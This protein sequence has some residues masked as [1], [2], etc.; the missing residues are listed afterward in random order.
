MKAILITGG[1][2]F[3]GSNLTRKILEKGD[4]QVVCLD[5][6]DPFYPK[7]TK[8]KNIEPFLKNQNYQ[9][10]EGDILKQ[11]DLDI[12]PNVD[13]I[14]H[15]AA[16]TGVRP[17][18]GDAVKYHEVNSIG[19]QM[20]LEFARHR[21]IQKF[22]FASSSSVYGMN[23]QLPW[24]E[25]SSLFPIS[26]YASSK[27][28]AEIMGYVY[29][30][31]YNIRFLS[32]RLFTVYGPGQR[33][34]LAIRNFFDAILSEVPVSVFGDGSSKRDYTYIDDV[35][36][37]IES[38]LHFSSSMYEIFNI[39]GQNPISLNQLIEEI[40]LICNRKAVVNRFPSQTGDVP[41]TFADIT[42]AKAMINYNP[43]HTIQQGLAK[44]FDWVKSAKKPELI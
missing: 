16:K 23:D 22:I 13:A 5:N 43:S 36:D 34:D 17:S 20:L 31:L 3:I 44:H 26:P 10:I 30:S 15:L 35:L 21:S 1:A 28:A 41:Y 24:S 12:V 27:A 14:I 33:P 29:S 42:K 4:S 38:A 37:A 39:G 40:E 2:G 11:D 32:L 6:L 8:R 19:T 18:L 7:I 25:R 9:F